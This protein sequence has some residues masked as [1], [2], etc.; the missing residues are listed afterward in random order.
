MFD[1]DFYENVE[2][3]YNKIYSSTGPVE[4]SFWKNVGDI[5]NKK[6]IQEQP[7]TIFE[8]VLESANKIIRG[9]KSGK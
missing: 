5:V 1:N 9:E 8:K 7:Q 3:R 6:S 2:K 4:R